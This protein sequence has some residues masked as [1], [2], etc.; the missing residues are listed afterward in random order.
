VSSNVVGPTCAVHFVV[1]TAPDAPRLDAGASLAV[2]GATSWTGLPLASDPLGN[3]E[4][5]GSGIMLVASASAPATYTGDVVLPQGAAITYKATTSASGN[6]I[7]ERSGAGN[8]STTVPSA[9]RTTIEL[10]WE[11]GESG[12]SPS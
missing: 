6:V 2:A 1:H 4:H 8:R 3:W 9:A 11:N 5:A 10:A 7:Y 12:R